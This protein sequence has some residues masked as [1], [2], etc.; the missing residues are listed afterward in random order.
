MSLVLRAVESEQDVNDFLA[1]REEVDPQ[2]PMTRESFEE[3]HA[4][5]GRLD[6]LADRDGIP[7][8]AGFA[9]HQF[10]DPSS[11]TGYVSIRVLAGHRR[12]GAGTQML[13]R[14]SEHVRGFGGTDLHAMFRSDATELV[15]FFE[16]RGFSEVGRVQDVELELA[17]AD[18]TIA[19]P[20]G[21]AIVRVD[22]SDSLDSGMRAVSLEADP[23]IPTAAPI[24]TGSLERWRERHRGRLHLPELSFAALA[25]DEVVGFA[26]LGKSVPGVGEHWM[27]GVKRAWR[28]RGIARALKQSQIAAA[29]AAGLERLRTQNDL[30]NAPM[31]R[32]NEQLGYRSRLE[33]IQFAGPLYL[34]E[35]G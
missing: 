12:R 23:D 34:S 25:G 26:I 24:V 30:A 1:V 32:V 16:H 7:V 20:E 28:G 27:T 5:P 15:D 33:L 3:E 18:G 6:L 35:G 17:G 9:E 31:R 14:L 8:G 11:K 4:Q 2:Q 29:Q 19:V 21:I 10:G 13:A 22:D